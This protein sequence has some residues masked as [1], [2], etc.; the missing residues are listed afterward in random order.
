MAALADLGGEG[1]LDEIYA[2]VASRRTD[3]PPSWTAIIRA[4]IESSSSDSANFREGS[5]D[6]FFSVGGIGSGRWGLRA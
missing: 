5:K 1:Y 2:G 3:L 6:L 4:T